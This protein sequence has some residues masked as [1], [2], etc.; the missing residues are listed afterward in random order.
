MY[1]PDEDRNPGDY[2]PPPAGQSDETPSNHT[3]ERQ[4]NPRWNGGSPPASALPTGPDGKTTHGWVWTGSDEYDPNGNWT[5]VQGK[6]IG[7]GNY[8]VGGGPPKTGGNTNTGGTTS[9][10]G[11][12]TS[13]LAGVP[14]SYN[15]QSMFSGS[16]PTLDDAI[17]E[18]KKLAPAP[19][20][21]PYAQFQAPQ[22]VGLDQR[23]QI[24]QA[25]LNKPQVMD[26]RTQD[27]LFEQQKELQN[28]LAQQSRER[29]AQTGAG[30]GL[31]SN[32]GYAAATNAQIEGDFGRNLLQSQRDIAVK[33]ADLNRQSELAAVQMQE[34]LSQGDFNRAAQAYQVQLQAQ[35]LYDELRFK[36]AEFDRGNVA[37]AAQNLMAGRQ[38]N[39]AEGVA[40]FQ[41]Y[42]A[43]RQMEEQMRQFNEQMG[44][45]WS[46]F[47]WDQIIGA[48][49]QFK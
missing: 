33:A 34:A 24:M 19:T 49:G 13:G 28:S 2:V 12:G 41:Q 1:N 46:K 25:V 43:Q 44:L 3:A 30:R 9:R 29:A 39:M 35:N 45:N 18:S 27:Q 22:A 8:N 14:Q 32:G 26:Q 11:G 47:G 40:S 4:V 31:Q 37:L 7:F 10:P 21:S 6:G 36:A 48:T 5:Q 38:Q 42:L 16:V 17:R 23:N 15:G 20:I